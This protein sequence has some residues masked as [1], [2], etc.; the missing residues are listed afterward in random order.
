M[1]MNMSGPGIFLCAFKGGERNTLTI[2]NRQTYLNRKIKKCPL[3]FF[4]RWPV[5]ITDWEKQRTGNCSGAECSCTGTNLISYTRSWKLSEFSINVVFCFV[6]KLG[7]FAHRAL[8]SFL[9]NADRILKFK[10][11]ASCAP[12]LKSSQLCLF[13]VFSAVSSVCVY[14]YFAGGSETAVINSLAC[15]LHPLNVN[16]NLGHLLDVFRY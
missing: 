6:F 12:A 15:S 5:K 13:T 3:T 9:V 7:F 11:R 14:A 4:F 10:I 16:W 8:F 2:A 1:R